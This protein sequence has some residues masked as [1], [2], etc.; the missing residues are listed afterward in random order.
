MTR[1]LL[2]AEIARSLRATHPERAEEMVQ[3]REKRM[4]TQAETY[5]VMGSSGEYSDS[6]TWPVLAFRVEA[7]AE[8]YALRAKQR[9]DEITTSVAWAKRY[10]R[11]EE[12]TSELDAGFWQNA[13]KDVDYYVVTVPL[14]DGTPV[15]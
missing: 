4:P 6:T 5:V 2:L 8:R 3:E 15:K 13:R 11:S 9:A 7:E 14:H 12:V 10:E 1:D